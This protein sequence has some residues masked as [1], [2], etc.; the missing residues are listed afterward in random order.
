MK[1]K[2]RNPC[3]IGSGSLSLRKSLIDDNFEGRNPCFIGSGSLS[4]EFL[5]YLKE[6][7]VAILVLL[8]VVLCHEIC[9]IIENIKEVAILVLLEVVLCQCYEDLLNYFVGRNP[10]FIGSG[11][12]SVKIIN[13]TPHAIKSQSLFYWKWFSVL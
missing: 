13:T 6:M 10:C 1:L 9:Y 4:I 12:L 3:F 11:S 7:T 2:S 5:I 8:E